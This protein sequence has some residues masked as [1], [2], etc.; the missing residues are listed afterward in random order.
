MVEFSKKFLK[1]LKK[2][3][4]KAEAKTLLQKLSQTTPSE[5]DF[6]IHITGITLREKRLKSF[7]YYFIVKEKEKHVVTRVELEEFFIKF[8]AMS[9]K[10]NQQVVIDK[11]KEDLKKVGFEL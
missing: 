7:R 2:H 3:S 1:E 5:G 11:L 4:S 8:I 6:I 9:K 10:N